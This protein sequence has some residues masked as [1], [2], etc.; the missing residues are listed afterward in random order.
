MRYL[1]NLDLNKNELQNARIQNL[2]IAPE[3][4]VS[5]QI[6]FNTTDKKYYGFTDSWIDLGYKYNGE[7]FTTVLK[8]KLDG[9]A[10]GANKYIHPAGTNPH[11]ATKA[12]VGLGNVENKSSSTI[13]D[14]LT[15]A[16]IDKALGFT[17]KKILQGTEASRPVATGSLIVYITTDTKKIFLDIGSSTWLQVG[18]Q[19]T[20]DWDNVIGKPTSFPP[21]AHTHTLAGLSEKSY[22]SLTDKPS[23]GSAA[24]K[25]TGIASGQVPIVG[26]DGKLATSLIPATAIT[27]TFVVSNQ[28]AMLALDVQ[29]GDV[30]V[31]T[32]LN[33]TFIL[34]VVP[35][36]VLA[37]W[38]E[39]L[40]PTD[41]VTSV[42]G[43]TGA[44][45][46]NKSHVGLSAVDNVQQASKVEFNTHNTDSI[47]HITSSERNTWNSRTRK[48][49]IDIG[50]GKLTTIPV[51]HS[52]GTTDVTVTIRE[53][54]SPYSVVMVDV[55]FIDT[56]K[57]NI[58][59]GQAPTL[60]QYRVT[61]VG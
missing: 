6:Y 42:N 25:N 31:R 30:C 23:L 3:G 40:T 48:Y 41:S 1:S 21:V 60:N 35:A 55:Q 52:F 43:M 39:L 5:G 51:T 10:E 36:T 18:G 50:D 29:V 37:N 46:L 61:V 33:K 34:K 16:N 27:D 9:I 13:R 26:A 32:D 19:D 54:A 14:E 4:A 57:F 15:T 7:T 45:T 22:K 2:A 20:I 59:F 12:D 49:S 17:P 24:S 58:L 44:V 11:G 53:K 47:R 38:Q 28:A 8:N 56:T